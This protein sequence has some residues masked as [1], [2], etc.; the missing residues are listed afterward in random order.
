MQSGDTVLL[1]V[2]SG[3]R[4]GT[5]FPVVTG[6]IAVP[7]FGRNGDF[8]IGYIPNVADWPTDLGSWERF[9]CQVA[10]RDM[11]P[12]EWADVLP[13]RSYQHVCPQ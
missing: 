5:A 7:L 3:Q 12:T 6:T 2:A 9:A 4:M 11:T 1:D 8:V 13:N 10:G